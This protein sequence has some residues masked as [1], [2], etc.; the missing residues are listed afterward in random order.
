[1]KRTIL[2]LTFI[3]SLGTFAYSKDY[4]VEMNFSKSTNQ[5]N[6]LGGTILGIVPIYNISPTFYASV[7]PFVTIGKSYSDY[8]F[9]LSLNK[10]W[11][12]NEK[13][14]TLIFGGIGIMNLE[15]N[16]THQHDGFNFKERLGLGLGYKI[17]ETSSVALTGTIGHISNGGLTKNNSGLDG[18]SLGVRYSFKF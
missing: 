16:S 13:W 12:I 18:Y 10:T 14:F 8:G 5:S 4:S 3:L 1:M 11:D 2:L 15:N 17:N 9:I 6:Y 7:D